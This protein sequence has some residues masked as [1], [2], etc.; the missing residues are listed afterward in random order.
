MSWKRNLKLSGR[1]LLLLAVG[2][3][4]SSGVLAQVVTGLEVLKTCPPTASP[5]A[6]VG[7]TYTVQNLNPANGVINLAVTNQ[8]PIPGGPITPIEC[9]QGGSPVTMLGANGSPTDTCGGPIQETA[10]PCGATNILFTDLVSASANDTGAGLPVSG[11]SSGTV[12]IAACTPTPTNTPTNTPTTT[13]TNTPTD[14]PT[15]TPTNT[16]SEAPPVPTLSF[17]MMVLLGLLLAGTGL[18][19][20]RRQ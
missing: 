13:A 1:A 17:P 15:N 14:T 7:C 19:L 3:L 5:G 16:P 9:L 11:S 18:F 10:P 6:L 20:A 8:V 2:F 12:V 4:A